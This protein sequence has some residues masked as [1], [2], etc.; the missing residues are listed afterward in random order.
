MSEPAP[1]AEGGKGSKKKLVI[2]LAAVLLLGGGGAGAWFSGLLPR[3]LG[4]TAAAADAH[5]TEPAK[6]AAHGTEPAKPTA[7]GAKPEAE[8]TEA[9]GAAPAA[10]AHG[11]KPGDGAK[12]DAAS[13]YMDLPDIVAN[14]NGGPRRTVFV[15]LRAKLELARPEDGPALQAAMPR[16]LDLFQGYLREMRPEEL[17]GSGGTYRLREE[18]LARTNLAAPPARVNAVLFT[19]MV[20]Q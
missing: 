10:T 9:H 1:A 3:L 19:E 8:K 2:L 11:A 6:A 18:L 12:A 13:P 15:K 16:L 17:R 4:R 14:L 7:H 5:G 20:I